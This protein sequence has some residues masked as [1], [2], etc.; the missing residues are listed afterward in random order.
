[1]PPG[2][3]VTRARDHAGVSVSSGATGRPGLP[4]W[5]PSRSRLAAALHL[6]GAVRFGALLHDSPEVL[7]E[8]LFGPLPGISAQNDRFGLADGVTDPASLK[9]P[10][11]DIPVVTFPRANGPTVFK[12]SQVHQ[13]ECDL[14]DLVPIDRALSLV[15]VLSLS[16]L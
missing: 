15:D 5:L 14:V 8:Q 2:R 10:V 1:M 6:A 7:Q 11:Q 3:G 9:E 13:S 12:G 4:V 16:H